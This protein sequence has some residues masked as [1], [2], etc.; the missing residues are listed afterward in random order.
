MFA[1]AVI[2]LIVSCIPCADAKALTVSKDAPVN[3]IKDSGQESHQSDQCPPFCTCNCCCGFSINHFIQIELSL[4]IQY[5][6][7]YPPFS[8]SAMSS[9]VY[10]VWHPPAAA[11]QA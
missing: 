6:Q 9:M 7:I 1:I 8:S 3:I 11:K 10:S 2:I 4:E 5:H